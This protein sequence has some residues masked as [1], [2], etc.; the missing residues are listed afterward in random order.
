MKLFVLPIAT[1]VA[2]LAGCTTSPAVSRDAPRAAVA[3]DAGHVL[4]VDG[5]SVLLGQAAS[6]PMSLQVFVARV[7][8]LTA[9]GRHED[10]GQLVRIYPDLAWQAVLSP[11][12]NARTQR[13]I[14][15]WLDAVASPDRGGWALFVADR[16][17]N[18]H[19][20][21]TWEKQRASAW[22]A[23]RRGAFAD[24]ADQTL[25]PP[26]AGPTP[27]PALDAA[28]LRA[29]AMLAA[30]R[31][32]EAA[33]VFTQ[34]AQR[35]ASWDRR[36][37]AR[38]NLFATLSHQ[39]AANPGAASQTRAD[40]LS[41]IELS[42]IHDPMILRLL[43][44]TQASAGP[45]TDASS[46]RQ[47]Q[48]RLGRVELQRGSPQAALLAWRAAE[49][50]PG[51]EPTLNRLRLSQAEALIA[52]GQDEPAIA[53]LIGLART[54]VRPQALAMLGLVQMRRGQVDIALA[55][56]RE[57]VDATTA[58]AHPDVYADAGLALLST[59][60]RQTG[61]D[62]LHQARDAYQ[63]RGNAE[64][65]RQ[66]LTNQLHYAQAVNNPALA[67]QARQMLHKVKP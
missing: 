21:A 14:A 64:A 7:Q 41:M 38:A 8:Q 16:A 57:A 53:M 15:A 32:A 33:A 51:A 20:Y 22:S 29:T 2:A 6:P 24:V 66:L 9:T 5:E 50:E 63:S 58:L 44:E 47:I 25:T 45:S 43:L 55:V 54:D 35:A 37:A 59:G 28:R 12:T 34:A 62:L 49:T 46:P 18:P 36:V 67:T 19:R 61:L 27:W 52:L 60:D 48:A 4:R 30:G 26:G 42:A 13:T 23:L 3:G 40:A 11:N 56:F 17:E 1:I 39:L 10:A 65:L 31:P